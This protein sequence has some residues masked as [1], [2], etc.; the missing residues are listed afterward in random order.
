MGALVADMVEK[1]TDRDGGKPKIFRDSSVARAEDFLDTFQARNLTDDTALAALVSQAKA[2]VAGR[3]PETFRQS[4]DLRATVK[5]G[6]Q[7]IQAAIAPM[8]QAKPRR[9]VTFTDQ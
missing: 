4:A 5:A 2:L 9:S 7:E 8:L 3:D 1:M 6:F